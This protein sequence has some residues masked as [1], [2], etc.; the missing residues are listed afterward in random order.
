M[1]QTFHRFHG[2]SGFLHFC[3]P[4]L[5]SFTWATLAVQPLHFSLYFK[6]TVPELVS[7]KFRRLPCAMAVNLA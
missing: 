2:P 5:A 6:V 7:A 1:L 4:Y 3:L